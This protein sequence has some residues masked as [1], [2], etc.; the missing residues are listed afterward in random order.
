M[1]DDTLRFLVGADSQGCARVLRLDGQLRT[2]LASWLGTVAD[3]GSIGDALA[4]ALLSRILGLG[5]RAPSAAF[6]FSCRAADGTYLP[7]PAG[8]DRWG[9]VRPV[10]D[11]YA[12]AQGSLLR[13]LVEND[14]SVLGRGRMAVERIMGNMPYSTASSNTD[15]SYRKLS[16]MLMQAHYC[17]TLAQV[18]PAATLSSPLRAAVVKCYRACSSLP[19][20]LQ[21]ATPLFRLTMLATIPE[22]GCQEST[23]EA[24]DAVTTVERLSADNG[25]AEHLLSDKIDERTGSSSRS[26][27]DLDWRWTYSTAY[28][29]IVLA[30]WGRSR[31]TPVA[32]RLEQVLRTRLRQW[33]AHE[34]YIRIKQLRAP[35]GGGPTAYSAL[36]AVSALACIA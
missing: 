4:Q 20:A 27:H 21:F 14:A 24:G 36:V 8:D 33:P 29:L 13:S 1:L 5:E 32:K 16:E 34:K 12:T 18:N 17:A 28:G 9:R 7:V 23:W 26:R 11:V 15:F 22:F 25:M 6:E 10:A 35:F 2:S 31:S 30:R 3:P 19:F